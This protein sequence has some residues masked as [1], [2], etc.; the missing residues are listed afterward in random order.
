MPTIFEQHVDHHHPCQRYGHHICELT[1]HVTKL[2]N[3]IVTIMVNSLVSRLGQH[4]DH[5]LAI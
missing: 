1:A 2:V 3:M 5:Y 4:V